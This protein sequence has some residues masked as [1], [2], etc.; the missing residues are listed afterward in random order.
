MLMKVNPKY[1]EIEQVAYKVF[2]EEIMLV[3]RENSLLGSSR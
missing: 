1:I 2:I 3:Y